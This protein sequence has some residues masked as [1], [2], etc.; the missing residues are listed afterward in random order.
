MR[1]VC[2]CGARSEP[3][4]GE[5]KLAALRAKQVRNN[6]SHDATTPETALMFI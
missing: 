3:A 4:G 1:R 5:A 2:A 6:S